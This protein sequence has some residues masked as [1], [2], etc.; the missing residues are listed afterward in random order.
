MDEWNRSISGGTWVPVQNLGPASSLGARRR[1]VQRAVHTPCLADASARGGSWSG[2]GRS[3]CAHAELSQPSRHSCPHAPRHPC[4]LLD[5]RY[6]Q[7]VRNLICR[8]HR[9]AYQPKSQLQPCTGCSDSVRKTLDLVFDLSAVAES[10]FQVCR[11][12]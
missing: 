2:S 4:G 5:D 10:L 3:A 9:T 11:D 6:T 12:L 8:P 1:R 7:C